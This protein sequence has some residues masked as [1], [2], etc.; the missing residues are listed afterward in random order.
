[1]LAVTTLV[2]IHP[3]CKQLS[4]EHSAIRSNAVILTLVET[5]LSHSYVD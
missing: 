5:L 1:M 3:N 2:Y 4:I